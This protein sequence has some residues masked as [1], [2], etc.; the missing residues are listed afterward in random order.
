MREG[1]ERERRGGNEEGGVNGLLET[2]ELWSFPLFWFY[3]CLLYNEIIST[4]AI[5]V[6]MAVYRTSSVTRSAGV[7]FVQ[8]AANVVATGSRQVNIIWTVMFL[9]LEIV[10]S[11]SS[12]SDQTL[13]SILRTI[14]N[15][16][17][18]VIFCFAFLLAVLYHGSIAI[19]LFSS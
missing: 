13:S 12:D 9:S 18:V 14:R 15:N 17:L 1:N 8:L 11:F 6:M 7:Q 2:L 19:G 5:C 16:I 3:Q 10:R 4:F